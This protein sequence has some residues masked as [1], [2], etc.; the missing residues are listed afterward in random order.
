MENELLIGTKFRFDIYRYVYKF[1]VH[2]TKNF[3]TIFIYLEINLI[4]NILNI[5]H[6]KLVVFTTI[7]DIYLKR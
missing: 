7:F 2:M 6:I 5:D 3:R 1:V 4:F